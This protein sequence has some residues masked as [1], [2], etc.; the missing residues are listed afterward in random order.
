RHLLP[1]RARR[2]RDRERTTVPRPAPAP[3]H[4]R[5]AAPSALDLGARLHGFFRQV[6]PRGSDPARQ[7]P[8]PARVVAGLEGA[9]ARRP[10]DR[11]RGAVDRSDPRRAGRGCRRPVRRVPALVPADRATAP[12]AGATRGTRQRRRAVS[13]PGS[14]RILHVDLGTPLAVVPRD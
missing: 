8:G 6:V 5:G 4:A 3:A 14:W 11:P 7:V 9:S 1:P 10:H 12:R 13:T 2:T